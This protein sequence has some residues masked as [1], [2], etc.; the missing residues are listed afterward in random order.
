M[1]A[2]TVEHHASI[3]A[4]S[5]LLLAACESPVQLSSS[6]VELVK[7]MGFPGPPPADPTNRFA[8]DPQA[9]VLGHA[10]FFDPNL[11]RNGEISCA[12]CHVPDRAFTDGLALNRGLSQGVRNTLSILDC[13]HQQWFNW[14]GQFDS[15]WS[16]AHGPMLHPREMGSSFSH[17]TDR[18][19]REPLLRTQYEVVFGV[20]PSSPLSTAQNE[21]VVANLGKAIAAYERKIVTGPS[22][23][24]RWVARWRAAGA[25]SALDR[26]AGEDFSVEAQ[27]GLATFTSNAECWKCHV[28]P[29]LSDGEFHAL[30][31]APRND[32]IADAARFAAIAKLQ[33]N[34]YRTSGAHSDAP[35]S[36]QA[37]VVDSLVARPDQWGAFRTPTLRNV[38]KTSPYF[39]QGQFET[40]EQV[41]HFYSTLEGAITIDHHRESVLRRTNLSQREIEGLLAFL[42]SL[43][44]TP[45]PAQWAV[46]PW[47]RAKVPA[48]S[49]D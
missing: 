15:L 29:L 9:A 20:L 36:E 14:D 45:P 30:G 42:R 1:R 31:A 21:S 25:P 47:I 12:T 26:V 17:I 39:H 44:G 28:G 22:P 32:L 19:R 41:L 18:V 16:Q 23:F 11:S 7:E 4:S 33:A 10:L 35:T 43:D 24:D 37:M 6:Q 46:D 34:P 40:L 5:L 3:I 49:P 48:V 27:R 8:D 2:R 38:E 13:A